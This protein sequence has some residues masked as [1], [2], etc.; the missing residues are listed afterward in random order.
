MTTDGRTLVAA[1]L[2]ELRTQRGIDQIEVAEHVGVHKNTIVRHEVGSNP[3]GAKLETA[4]TICRA[5]GG[6]VGHLL[7]LRGGIMPDGYP[8]AERGYG[9]GE[10]T[11]EMAADVARWD[12]ERQDATVAEQARRQ[13]AQLTSTRELVRALKWEAFQNPAKIVQVWL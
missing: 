8:A 11:P 10:P 12:V 7:N 1:Y 5:L 6:D 4:I 3:E 13:G 9:G 2:K